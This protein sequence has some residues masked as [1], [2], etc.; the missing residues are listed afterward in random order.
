MSATSALLFG[1]GVLGALAALFL[2]GT[3]AFLALFLP[4]ACL[5]S[6]LLPYAG[7][8]RLEGISSLEEA[9]AAGR[10]SGLSGFELALWAEGIAARRF[11]Y[12]RRN[13]WDSPERCFARGYGYCIQQARALRLLCSGLGLEAKVVQAFRCR[14]PATIVHGEA[15]GPGIG[16]H[17]WVRVS[18]EGSD[19][20]L[21]SALPTK[22]PGRPGFE[23]L[24][25]VLAPPDFA[26]TVLHV[27]SAAENARR[28]MRNILG[29]RPRS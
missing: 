23:A 13:P 25:A 7:P 28:D 4:L 8:K 24:S 5:G 27:L 11:E 6:G 12:S 16:G 22:G 17:A 9:I 14:F 10:S 2:A 21:D 1:L 19:L 26:M 3:A 29:R 20:D 18:I 15:V